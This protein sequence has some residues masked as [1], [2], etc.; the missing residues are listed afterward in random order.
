[1]KACKSCGFP[2]PAVKAGKG[3]SVFCPACGA[4]TASYFV[5]SKAVEEW[6][7]MNGEPEPKV[8]EKP[9]KEKAKGKKG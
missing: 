8:E 9:K 2:V 1:M 4:S 3:F 6:E 5:E 7:Q